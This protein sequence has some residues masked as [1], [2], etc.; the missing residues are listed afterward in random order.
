M[1]FVNFAETVGQVSLMRMYNKAG[2]LVEPSVTTVQSA[3]V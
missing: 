3:M 2:F 1:T